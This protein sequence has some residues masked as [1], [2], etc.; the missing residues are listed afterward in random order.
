MSESNTIFKAI[1]HPARRQILMLLARSD[2][3]VKQLTAVFEMSQPAVSQHLRELREAK[4]VKSLKIGSEQ[5]YRLNGAP[6]E[7]VFDWAN[8]YRQFFDPAGHAWALVSEPG[9]PAK[10]T[11]A[12][13]GR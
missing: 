12:R 6:L 7:K 3:S 10:K 2:H 11:G 8:Q 4:L 9:K 5:R 13:S 1:A